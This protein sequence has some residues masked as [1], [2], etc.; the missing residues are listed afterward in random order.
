MARLYRLRYFC[1]NK[2]AKDIKFLIFDLLNR[3]GY[4]RRRRNGV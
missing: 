2:W 3:F 4:C 1:E